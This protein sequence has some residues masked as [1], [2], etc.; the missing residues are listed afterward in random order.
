MHKNRLKK[1]LSKQEDTFH[2]HVIQIDVQ[3]KMKKIIERISD[4]ILVDFFKINIAGAQSSHFYKAW[5]GK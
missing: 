5:R 1:P 4:G 3:L 2:F